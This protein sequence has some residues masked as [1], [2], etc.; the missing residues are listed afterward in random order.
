MRGTGHRWLQHARRGCVLAT[1]WLLLCAAGGCTGPGLEP[2]AD[3]LG[4]RPGEAGGGGGAAAGGTGG[5]APSV[6]GDASSGDGDGD[7]DDLSDAGEAAR[8]GGV[9]ED[10]GTDSEDLEP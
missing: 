8:D 3:S 6:P 9:D 1:A 5:G 7:G 10:G 4:E 2:P